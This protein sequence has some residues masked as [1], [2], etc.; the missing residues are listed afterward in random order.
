MPSR[1][2]RTVLS[3]LTIAFLGPAAPG[4]HRVPDGAATPTTPATAGAM[5]ASASPAQTAPSDP[6][7]VILPGGGEDVL[8]KAR[9]LN[10]AAY[11]KPPSR[12]R[13]GHVTP[14][15]LAAKAV[16]KTERGFEVQLPS[17]A[18]ITTPTVYRDT[19]FVSGGFHSKE[20]YALTAKEGQLVWALNLDDDGPSASAC[21][22]GVC[23]FNTE[24]CTIFAV[25]A[26]TGKLLWSWWLGD[27]LMSAP[28]IA[29]G[30]VFS[31]YP[32]GGGHGGLAVQQ[33]A[34]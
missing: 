25:E 18:P 9:K 1:A 15:K 33:Q 22:D 23:V 28:T 17:K 5:A 30:R 12:F 4:C 20:F 6:D 7:A 14:R 19:L 29:H 26:A 13:T 21:E 27:P 3:L 31:S 2:R 24:S 8:A 16:R 32:V 11:A 34:A 10:S